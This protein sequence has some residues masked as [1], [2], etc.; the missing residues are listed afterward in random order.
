[1][2]AY[3]FLGQQKDKGS[4]SQGDTAKR[5]AASSPS[6]AETGGASGSDAPKNVEAGGDE[7]GGDE[8]GGATPSRST[9]GGPVTPPTP[10]DYRG[11]DLTRG[12]E[13]ALADDPVKPKGDGGDLEYTLS[14]LTVE[15]T[16]GRLILLRNGQPGT[17]ETCVNETRYATLIER[18]QMSKGTRVC[19]QNGAG[20]VSL[21][22][23]QAFSPASD[24]SEYISFDLTVW[25][26]GMDVEQSN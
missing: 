8:P 11:I 24:P 4:Q 1:M 25:R 13:I 2:T 15:S 14:G 9:G 12:Y 3:Y 21:I 23:V 22:T 17:L 19:F 26:G 6:P 7:P 18:A 10:V 5:G 20:D 16:G